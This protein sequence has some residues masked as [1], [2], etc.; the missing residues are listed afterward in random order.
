MS[1]APYIVAADAI[2]RVRAE[3]RAAV[4]DL[5]LPASRHECAWY[6]LRGARNPK[7]RRDQPNR[8]AAVPSPNWPMSAVVIDAREPQPGELEGGNCA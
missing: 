6:V 8:G 2:A 5:T 1:T 4:T 3:A 7:A